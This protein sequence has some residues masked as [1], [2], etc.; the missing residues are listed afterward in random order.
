M[1]AKIEFEVNAHF[2]E[3]TKVIYESADTLYYRLLDIDYNFKDIS[4]EIR[5]NDKENA[6]ESKD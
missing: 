3:A 1:K 2:D 6:N 4:I 5:T